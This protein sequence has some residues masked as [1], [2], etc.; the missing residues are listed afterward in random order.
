[1]AITD[2]LSTD[3]SQTDIDD[4]QLELFFLVWLDANA[5]FKILN[6]DHQKID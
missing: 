6:T 4:K 5:N 2:V 3:D 1:M